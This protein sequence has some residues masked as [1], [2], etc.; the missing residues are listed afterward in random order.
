MANLIPP[1]PN[2]KI[3]EG[4]P[5]R[6]WFFNLGTYIQV[7]QVGGS[8]WTVAQGGTG[9]STVS[10]YLKGAGSTIS[11]VAQIPYTDISGL[12]TYYVPYTGATTDVTL[13][14]HK[15][16]AQSVSTGPGTTTA[17]TAP[18]YFVTGT[19]TTTPEQGAME[20]SAGH[21]FFS[22][23]NGVRYGLSMSGGVKTTTTT[24]T[25]TI[26]ETTLYSYSFAANEFHLDEDISCSLTGVYSNASASDDFTIRFKMNGVTLI[27]VARVAGNV[28]NQGW[29]AEYS[30]TIRSIGTT[31]N[32]V[33]FAQYT[34][35]ITNSLQSTLAGHTMDTTITGL[36]EVTIQWVNAKAGNTFSC[37][38]GM[39]HI[40]H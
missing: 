3:E 10:G 11:G 13:G 4:H 6:E 32:F 24:V 23:I 1:I 33:D 12:S 5:W 2:N 9:L 28:T 7:A 21:L 39:L 35:G 37:S 20:F 26:T 40:N 30:G 29:K 19:N 22:P 16:S 34:D 8:P 36:F 15:L 27:A 38:R 31:G 14:T 17:G 25:N 18:L